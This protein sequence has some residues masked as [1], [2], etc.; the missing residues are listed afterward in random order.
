MRLSSWRN[1][2][3]SVWPD[4]ATTIEVASLHAEAERV[5]KHTRRPVGLV[6]VVL[7]TAPPSGNDARARA[8]EMLRKLGPQVGFVALVVEGDGFRPASVRAMFTGIS[9][10]LSPGFPWRIFRTID[11]LASWTPMG[12]LADPASIDE[13]RA[14][15]DS[16]RPEAR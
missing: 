15:S 9:L 6:L 8:V 1:V 12:T 5:A 16:L 3:V 7:E 11:E 10:L 2:V 4:A 14:L 13:L